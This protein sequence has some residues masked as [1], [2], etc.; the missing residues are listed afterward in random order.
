MTLRRHLQPGIRYFSVTWEPEGVG[1]SEW[2]RSE[3]GSRPILKEIERIPEYLKA[4]DI[5][6]IRKDAGAYV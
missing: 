3:K 2:W 6:E 1:R 5:G 4:G